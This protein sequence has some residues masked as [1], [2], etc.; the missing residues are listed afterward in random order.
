[1][2]PSD[3]N[4]IGAV[5]V[6]AGRG[7]RSGLSGPKQ[8]HELAGKTVL[9]KTFEALSKRIDP[10]N[11]VIV[12]HAD[13]AD[14]VDQ[15][16][17]ESGFSP[18]TTPGGDTRQS[19]VFLGLRALSAIAEPPTYVMIHDAARPFVSTALL[20]TLTEEAANHPENGVLPVLPIADTIKR[21]DGDLVAETI[22][23]TNLSTAQTPQM[24]PLGAIIEAHEAAS[25]V[26]ESFTDDS[27]IFEWY[28]K[29]VRTI[30]G[31]KDNFKLTYA[32]DFERAEKIIKMNENASPATPDIRTGHGYDVHRF[33]TGD[34]VMLCGIEVPHNKSLLGHSDADV[35]LH[36]LTDALL[37][38]C[39]AG[40]IGDH[41]PPSDPKWKAAES[42]VFLREAVR[43]VAE[44]GGTVLN[45]DVTLICETPKIGP[46]RMKMREQLAQL[47]GIAVDRCSVKATT[48]EKMGFIGREEGMCAMATASV[49]YA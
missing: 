3:D 37:A 21:V 2:S 31:E 33:T 10:E 49:R 29:N 42:H 16:F 7:S 24:F 11:I 39:A 14:Q 34:H 27:S 13:D 38:T 6:A 8:F 23:R 5:I 35:G 12:R 9:L 1:M 22:P 17:A 25:A 47:C 26:E 43:I 40:D 20:D 41:F 46:H 30:V 44:R 48:N 28:G 45:V 32:A 15:A 19:S 36:A 4:S 18:H